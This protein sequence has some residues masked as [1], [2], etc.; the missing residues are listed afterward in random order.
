[1]QNKDCT[2]FV[3]GKIVGI[4]ESILKEEIGIIAGSR[5]IISV[6]FELLDNNDE[7]FLFFVGIESQTDH[8]PVDFERR[9]WSSEALERK[10]KEIAE[11]ESD[12]REDVF[13]A[14]QKLINRF[15]MKNI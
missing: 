12:L 1:M 10:D 15:D 5:K 6:G 11:F 7:D 14:C 9:N 13:K 8:L 4:C 2:N 3:R